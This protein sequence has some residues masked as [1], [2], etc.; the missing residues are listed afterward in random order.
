MIVKKI[1]DSIN[2]S[3]LIPSE[4]LPENGV[5]HQHHFKSTPE[6]NLIELCGRVCY[7]SAKSEKSRSSEDYHKHIVDVNHL[8]VIEHVNLTFQI[9]QPETSEFYSIFLNRPGTFLTKGPNVGEFFLHAN[10]RSIR[11]WDSFGLAGAGLSG[12]GA[13]LLGNCLK[14]LAKRRCPLAMSD[15][16]ETLV[17]PWIQMVT[18]NHSEA[19]WHSF[20]FGEVSRGFS[21][22]LVRHKYRTAVSQRSTR[23]CDESE[24]PWAFHPEINI[25]RKELDQHIA[26]SF[27]FLENGLWNLENLCRMTYDEVVNFLELKLIDEG[28]DRFTARKTARGAARGVLGNALSTELIFSASA[29]QW[30]RIIAQRCSPHADGEIAE[31]IGKVRDILFGDKLD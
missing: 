2:R 10:L 30:E 31:A 9:F 26:D 6:D 22:E 3:L 5:P 27:K 29:A 7:D 24:S 11:E 28:K 16:G 20:Y 15:W 1:F 4:I 25:R 13:A 14:T 21:H 18:P 23:Y 8:S 12:N 19:V 17:P